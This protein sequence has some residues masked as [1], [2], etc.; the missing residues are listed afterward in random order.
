MVCMMQFII[1]VMTEF[2]SICL[3]CGQDE[4]QDVIILFIALAIIADFDN[5]FA[6]SWDQD[7][8]TEESLGEHFPKGTHSHKLNAET[9]IRSCWGRCARF[10]YK[11]IRLIYSTLYFYYFPLLVIPFTYIIPYYYNYVLNDGPPADDGDE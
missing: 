10:L 1:G 8:I 11:I 4:M 6:E 9:R 2:F 7:K 3:V 5:F